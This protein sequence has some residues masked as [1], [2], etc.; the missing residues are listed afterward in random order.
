[1]MVRA[2]LPQRT[3]LPNIIYK[4]FCKIFSHASK[5]FF[6]H[7]GVAERFARADENSHSQRFLR[8]DARSDKKR[9]GTTRGLN[10]LEGAE[11]LGALADLV[12][13][14]SHGAIHRASVASGSKGGLST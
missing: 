11:W 12:V 14:E 13:T 8:R 7:R 10:G 3:A 2:Q 9:I 5:F 1:V 4:D 6:T